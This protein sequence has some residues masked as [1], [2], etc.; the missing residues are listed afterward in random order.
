M[1][2]SYVASYGTITASASAGCMQCIVSIQISVTWRWP[3]PTDRNWGNVCARK[4]FGH[5]QCATY[6]GPNS[7]KT[8]GAYGAYHVPTRT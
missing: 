8:H 4:R 3:R 7:Y 5:E 2:R 6:Q 1:L